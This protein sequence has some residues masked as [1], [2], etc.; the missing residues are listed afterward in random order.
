MN[1]KVELYNPDGERKVYRVACPVCG[2]WDMFTQ[3]IPKQIICAVCL[4][5]YV[6]TAES[7]RI[8]AYKETN[9]L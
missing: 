7:L 4:T 2:T 8:E 3:F 6:I 1:P 5:E 9:D